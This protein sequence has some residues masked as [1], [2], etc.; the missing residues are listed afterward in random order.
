MRNS[1]RCAAGPPPPPPPAQGAPPPGGAGRVGAGPTPGR[2]RGSRCSI[3]GLREP[4][5]ASLLR[6]LVGPP[7]HRSLPR[8]GE[9]GERERASERAGR[10]GSGGREG[11]LFTATSPGWRQFVAPPASSSPG[12][13]ILRGAGGLGSARHPRRRGDRHPPLGSAPPASGTP[14]PLRFFPRPSLSRR[15]Y[16]AV[17]P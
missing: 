10:G 3:A 4:L 11:F 6:S 16:P 8:L 17:A 5:A 7:L 12:S 1:A 9:E 14:R 15:R 2:L 13:E